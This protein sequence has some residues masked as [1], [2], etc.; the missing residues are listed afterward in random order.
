MLYLKEA[1]DK[2]SIDIFYNLPLPQQHRAL[3]ILD[4]ALDYPYLVSLSTLHQLLAALWRVGI[5]ED[6]K[7]EILHHKVKELLSH[8]Q[9]VMESLGMKP[10][11]I[12]VAN[13]KLTAIEQKV[14][15]ISN[16]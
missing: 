3:D 2:L 1:T 4:L 10:P 16:N 14:T 8:T 5:M 11:L 13:H 15:N 9:I 12:A 6:N 7:D